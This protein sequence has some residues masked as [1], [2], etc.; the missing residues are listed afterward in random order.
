MVGLLLWPHACELPVAVHAFSDDNLTVNSNFVLAIIS[1]YGNALL[2]DLADAYGSG[3]AA[4][5]PDHHYRT[6]ESYHLAAPPL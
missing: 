3:A 4:S 2:F 1:Y 5:A 6:G